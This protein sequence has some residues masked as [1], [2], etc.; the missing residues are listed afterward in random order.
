MT[1]DELL[2]SSDWSEVFCE[3][4]SGGGVDGVVEACPPGT[5][6][7]LTLP[8]RADVVEI[9]AICEAPQ[10]F[11]EFNQWGG[12]GVFKLRDGRYLAAS[13]WCDT[14]GWDC[15]AGNSLEVGHTLEDVVMFGLSEDD[16]A[17]LELGG[18][19]SPQPA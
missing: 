17:K 16:R 10:G 18:D 1:I 6:I 19:A 13:G 5:T 8:K 4:N 11:Y 9:I 15:R 2:A 7:D 12:V 14:T 3:S